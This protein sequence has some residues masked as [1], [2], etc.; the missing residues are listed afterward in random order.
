MDTHL[1]KSAAFGESMLVLDGRNDFGWK[2]PATD[3]SLEEKN[4]ATGVLEWCRTLAYYSSH[5]VYFDTLKT[6]INIDVN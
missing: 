4:K 2:I 6:C 3:P 5:S 1:K